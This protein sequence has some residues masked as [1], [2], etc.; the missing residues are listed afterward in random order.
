MDQDIDTWITKNHRE[1]QVLES[2]H[3]ITKEIYNLIQIFIFIKNFPFLMQEGEKFLSYMRG[4]PNIH[5]FFY[6]WTGPK[7]LYAF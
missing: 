6:Y 7:R 5:F 3:Q 4:R 2:E 1:D